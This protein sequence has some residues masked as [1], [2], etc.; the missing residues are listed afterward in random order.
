MP[1]IRTICPTC[2]LVVIDASE[3]TLRRH[4]AADQVECSFTCPECEQPVVQPLADKMVP[5]LIGAGCAVADW[6]TD[7]SR[8]LHPS[9]TGRITEAEIAEFIVEL[10]HEDWMAEL[11]EH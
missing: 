7:D 8:S 2:D 9:M 11:F 6:E 5:V 3:L 1:T 10:E 4:H